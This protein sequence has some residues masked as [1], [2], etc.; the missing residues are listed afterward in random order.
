MVRLPAKLS[1]I[2]AVLLVLAGLLSVK[3][4][5]VSAF[6]GCHGIFDCCTSWSP[7]PIDPIHLP[8]ICDTT[9]GSRPCS[10][11]NATACTITGPASYC[12]SRGWRIDIGSNGCSWVPPVVCTWGPWVDGACDGGTCTDERRQ[13][14]W[15]SP[16]GCTFGS[17]CVSDVACDP[18]PPP[19]PP[20]SCTIALPGAGI[21]VTAGLTTTLS[22][23]ITDTNGTIDEVLF[24]VSDTSVATVCENGT[25]PCSAGSASENDTGAA[26]RADMTGGNPS[27]PTTI[28]IA[29]A[30]M[31]DEGGITCSDSTTVTVVN[32]SGWW[33][34]K[35]GDAVTNGNIRSTIPI[36]SCSASGTCEPYLIFNDTGNFP[37]VPLYFGTI[38]PSAPDI[39]TENWNTD[40]DYSSPEIYDY[41]FF[42][43]KIPVTG[44]AIPSNSIDGT[45]FT[46]SVVS[47]GYEWYEYD[48]AALG[49]NLSIN[50]DIDFGGRKIVLFVDDADLTLLGQV[51]VNDGVGL[52]MVIVDRSILVGPGVGGVVGP[53]LE[54]LYVVDEQ[55]ITG[56]SNLPLH[57]RGSVAANDRVVL[58]GQR[59]LD[60][61]SDAPAELFEYGADQIFLFPDDLTPRNLRWREVAP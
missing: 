3:T 11:A 7:N 10:G 47:D 26:F 13:T 17:R 31:V 56:S 19:P 15:T 5:P 42:A 8:P 6:H 43:N 34:V 55:F 27:P 29:T 4:S 9:A 23:V 45:A 35:E 58:A 18:P 16:V 33:Q 30:T 53:H 41:A 52:F 21:T 60:D 38:S 14:R 61:N 20:P 37:G 48:G 49:P 50:T 1:I 28:I 12:S 22:P 24:T 25:G 54:G 44:E 46:G 32:P 59:D 39:S 57:I 51:N 40:T 36:V 2:I